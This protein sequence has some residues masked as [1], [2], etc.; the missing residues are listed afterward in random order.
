VNP[1]A[2]SALADASPIG[3]R[4]FHVVVFLGFAG[5]TI[6]GMIP[7]LRQL[8]VALTHPWHF[9]TPPSPLGTAAALA[10]IFS[11][12]ALIVFLVRGRS[13]PLWMSVVML[14]AFG[15]SIWQQG[16][17][18]SRRSAPGAN[19]AMLD[20]GKAL[21]EKMRAQLQQSGAV[22]NTAA[23]WEA[24]LSAIAAENP[25]LVSPYRSRTFAIA[26]WKLRTLVKE[27]DFL[28]DA[29]P[30]TFTVFIPADASR[31]TI[32]MVGLDPEHQTVRLRDDQGQPFELKGAFAPDTRN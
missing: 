21:H 13:A 10:A 4:A 23:E 26:P 24:A 31:F 7:E 32:T 28:L 30:G 5:G 1:K 19:L 3:L 16:Y 12:L 18:F 27:G 2:P 6:A 9:G 25:R 17:V 11:S 15:V 20:M 22:P 29:T 14:V 8:F